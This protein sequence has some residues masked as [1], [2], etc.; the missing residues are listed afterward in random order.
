MFHSGTCPHCREKIVHIR[1]QDV[2]INSDAMQSMKGFS[3]QCPSCKSILGVQMNPDTL[4]EKLKEDILKE[5]KEMFK[6]SFSYH[7]QQPK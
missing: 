2:D 6:H 3:Y 5:L 7:R 1:V 4:N